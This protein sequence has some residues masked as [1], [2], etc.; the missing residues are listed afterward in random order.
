M[1]GKRVI[2]ALSL[3][4][5]T[6]TSGFAFAGEQPPHKRWQQSQ[7]LSAA[8]SAQAMA[9]DRDLVATPDPAAPYRYHGG[10]HP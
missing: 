8:R 1:I 2:A 7:T 3:L 4:V 5:F 6:M 10:P 9:N